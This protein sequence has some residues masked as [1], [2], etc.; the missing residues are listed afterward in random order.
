[1][2]IKCM[3][4]GLNPRK[5]NTSVVYWTCNLSITTI[6]WHWLSY[7]VRIDKI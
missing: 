1:M 3:Q 5:T 6:N 4:P 2:L 7:K